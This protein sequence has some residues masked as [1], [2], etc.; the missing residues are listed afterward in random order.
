MEAVCSMLAGVLRLRQ[1][2]G[3][4]RLRQAVGRLRLLQ[5]AALRLPSPFRE[6]LGGCLACICRLL[7]QL[8]ASLLLLL[9]RRQLSLLLLLLLL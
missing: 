3:R 6:Q 5:V 9:L 2:V 8:H 4:L 1:A 7:G